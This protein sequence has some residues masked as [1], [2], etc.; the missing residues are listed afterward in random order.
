MLFKK[1]DW[2]HPYQ[3]GLPNSLFQENRQKFLALLHAKIGTETN[4]IALFKGVGEVPLYNSD[5]NY[6]FY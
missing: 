2:T 4:S 5:V 6:P 1:E 3:E